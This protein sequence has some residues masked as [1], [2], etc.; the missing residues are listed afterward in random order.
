MPEE[1]HPDASWESPIELEIKQMAEAE[2]RKLV[3][4]TRPLSNLVL[5]TAG[6]GAL[7]VVLSAAFVIVWSTAEEIALV[8]LRSSSII[9]VLTGIAAICLGAY[10]HRDQKRAGFKGGQAGLAATC[11]LLSGTV[12][13]CTALMLPMLSTMREMLSP[14]S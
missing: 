2:K 3:V 9:W 10:V 14:S 1:S 12:I 13:I 7:N 4:D 5:T 6:L 11:A 8:I